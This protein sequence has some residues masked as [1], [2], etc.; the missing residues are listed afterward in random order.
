MR[1]RARI[2]LA[3]RRPVLAAAGACL[4][5]RGVPAGRFESLLAVSPDRIGDV[6]LATPAFKALADSSPGSRLTVVVREPLVEMLAPQPYISRVL[7]AG[8]PGIVSL[9]RRERF[10]VAVDFCCDHRLGSAILAR[11]SGAGCVVGYEDS[12]RGALLDVAGAK[13]KEPLHIRDL[14]LGALGPLAAEPD[15]ALPEL[16]ISPSAAQ[17]VRDLLGGDPAHLVGIHPGGF[18]PTQRW[19][20]ERFGELARALSERFGVAP[21]FLGGP[22]DPRIALSTP[23]ARD[24]SGRLSVAETAAAISMCGLLVCNNSGPLHVAT[25]LRIRTVSTMGP[26]VAARWWPVG[27]R[28][29]VIRKD[30]PCIGCNRG[31]CPLGTH[32]CMESISV[33]E[34]AEACAGLLGAGAG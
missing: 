8:S 19:R 16:C 22:G 15:R 3:I 12:G 5:K 23:G 17:R 34:M 18:Y 32:E 14:L 11:R 30:I 1:L 33:P 29:V 20:P 6:I 28:N 4:P 9:L 7:P 13:P 31:A 27:E 2:Y 24:L 25:A 26:T 21:L 10:D